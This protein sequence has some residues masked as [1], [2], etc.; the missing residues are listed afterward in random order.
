MEGKW[1]GKLYVEERVNKASGVIY[2]SMHV[3][4]YQGFYGEY[5]LAT[6]IGVTHRQSCQSSFT[7]F[8]CDGPLPKPVQKICKSLK[9]IHNEI[10]QRPDRWNRVG[11]NA[12]RTCRIAKIICKG[13]QKN[14]KAFYL[15]ENTARQVPTYWHNM[16]AK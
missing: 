8:W 12:L 1:M 2:A 5:H 3:S 10:S 11:W 7:V 9:T 13:A 6:Y 14:M 16:Q 15:F 4:R